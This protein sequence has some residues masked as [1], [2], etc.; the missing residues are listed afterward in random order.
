[1]NNKL[2][3]TDSQIIDLLGGC[4]K[5]AK[6]CRVSVPAVSMWRKKGI[7]ASQFV[8]LGAT[9]EA[10]SNGLISRKDIL[11]DTWHIVFPELLKAQVL[12]E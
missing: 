3:L 12:V 7:P 5:V 2:Q 6:L 9:L 4:T 10:Q 8:F 1:M 11:P